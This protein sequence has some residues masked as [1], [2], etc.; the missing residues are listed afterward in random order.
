ML[1]LD[2]ELPD[3]GCRVSEG[4]M[5]LDW[6]LMKNDSD[7][8]QAQMAIG[9]WFGLKHQAVYRIPLVIVVV[10]GSPRPA[11]NQAIGVHALRRD[12]QVAR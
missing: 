5:N 11:D 4:K 12:W 1:V 6:L 3:L 8:E 9:L 7:D 2:H 10:V